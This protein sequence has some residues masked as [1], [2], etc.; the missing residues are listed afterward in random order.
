MT[1]S[2]AWIGV[3]ICKKYLDVGSTTGTP[4][5]VANDADGRIALARRLKARTCVA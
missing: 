1:T 4:V 2:G 3:D 5:R